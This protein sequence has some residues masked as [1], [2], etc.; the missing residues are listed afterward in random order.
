MRIAIHK[1][2]L[3]KTLNRDSAWG[4]LRNSTIFFIL[5]GHPVDYAD[6]P[7]KEKYLD[8]FKILTPIE[9]QIF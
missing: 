7:I 4:F 1:N 2:V 3:V 8:I 5:T 6:D 9:W